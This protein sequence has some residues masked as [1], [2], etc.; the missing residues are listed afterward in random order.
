M[1]NLQITDAAVL[2]AAAAIQV[3]MEKTIGLNDLARAALVAALPHLAQE[4]VPVEAVVS[5]GPWE[6]FET[7]EQRKALGRA[8]AC[9]ERHQLAPGIHQ[10]VPHL[11][12]RIDL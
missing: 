12:E 3:R 8:D 2:A 7:T 4:T 10:D 9:Y 1:S 6:P 5:K 11:H